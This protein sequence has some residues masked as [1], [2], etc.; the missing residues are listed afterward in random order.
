M[1][2]TEEIMNSSVCVQVC[3]SVCNMVLCQI[4]VVWGA[5]NSMNWYIMSFNEN[6]L[7]DRQKGQI[8]QYVT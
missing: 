8:T 7:E 4:S 1:K 3:K 2:I 5:I 6:C